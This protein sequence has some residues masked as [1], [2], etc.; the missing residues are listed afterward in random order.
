M[1]DNN[2]LIVYIQASNRDITTR[3][4][5]RVIIKY[6]LNEKFEHTVVPIKVSSSTQLHGVALSSNISLLCMLGVSLNV[7]GIV[8]NT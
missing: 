1:N 8:G 2:N 4:Q 6:W 5:Y 3:K 7:R